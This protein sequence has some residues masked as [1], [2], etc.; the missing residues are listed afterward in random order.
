ME[1]KKLVH[2]VSLVATILLL[3]RGAAFAA[4]IPDTG[5]PNEPICNLRAYTDLGNGIISDDVT[6]LLW[7]K[8][9]APDTYNWRGAHDYCST[10]TLG[11]FSDWRL[12]TIQEL[13]TLVDCGI[14]APGPAISME[15]FPDTQPSFY[16]SST[17][18][19]FG[20]FNAWRVN[21]MN[22]YVS[23][24]RKAG[25]HYVRAVR[26]AASSSNFIDNGD[27]T[28]TDSSTGLMWE[29]SPAATTY[30]W[31]QAKDYCE[32]LTL[33]GHSDWR[34]PTRNEL[35]TLV[36]YSRFN[37]AISMSYFPAIR[38]SYFPGTAA[39]YYWTS[40]TSA[41]S[42]GVAWYVHFKYG[43][44]Y[45]IDKMYYNHVRAVRAGQCGP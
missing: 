1:R 37:P 29:Q 15:Y 45:F 2:V 17:A 42:F 36:N 40:T 18:G 16:W 39:S 23:Y 4:R 38:K 41:D 32:K 9:T 12:P 24:N 5:D 30:T 20:L 44:V 19:L 22:G 10:L 14:T 35:Q 28:I 7:Q 13:S 34:L 27:G 6:G 3:L 31:K 26:G 33:G 25:K 21:L 11:G 8:E 43:Y